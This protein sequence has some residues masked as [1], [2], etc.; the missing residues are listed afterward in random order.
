MV[1]ELMRQFY[2]TPRIYRIT[3]DSQPQ[4]VEFDNS[5]MQ[6]QTMIGPTGE[7]FKL[8]EPVYDIKVK[9]SKQTSYSRMAQNELAKELYGAGIFA[10]QNA[11]SALAVLDMMEFEGKDKVVQKVQQNGTMM[12]MMQQ[13]A[14]QIQQLQGMLGMQQPASVPQ[15]QAPA[16]E[17]PK[18]EPKTDSLGNEQQSGKRINAPVERA[19]ASTA[20]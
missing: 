17:P 13:M 18:E 19:A 7:E 11:D 8:H 2:D 3:G 9:P 14:M 20:V 5:M 10:P 6:G 15:Q 12:Q 16:S 4:Y 1:I